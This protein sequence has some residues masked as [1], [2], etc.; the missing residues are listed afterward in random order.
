[1]CR[2]M[3]TALA[4][5]KKTTK[6]L[7]TEDSYNIL[8]T[9]YGVDRQ[10][11][12]QMLEIYNQYKAFKKAKMLSESEFNTYEQFY[13]SLRQKAL[14]EITNDKEELANLAVEISYN[15]KGTTKE[16]CWDVFGN[17]MVYNIMNKKKENGDEIVEVPVMS[18]FGDFEYL[19]DK[20]G[21]NAFNFAYSDDA[22]EDEEDEFDSLLGDID[23]DDL[24]EDLE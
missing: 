4:D 18:E 22:T 14:E 12:K 1:M 7:K 20:Y 24:F 21:I 8:F 11:L 15:T 23:E 6:A 9:G 3:E 13:K 16:F 17:W 5:V 10:K 2:Y 19:G